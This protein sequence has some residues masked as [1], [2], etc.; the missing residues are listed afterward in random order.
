MSTLDPMGNPSPRC[1]RSNLGEVR[2]SE[3]LKSMLYEDLIWDNRGGSFALEVSY[4]TSP[5]ELT[6]W[7]WEHGEVVA[8]YNHI[9]RGLVKRRFRFPL[10]EYRRLLQ[11]CEKGA[12]LA[13]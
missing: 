13:A 2:I 7:M 11:A 1:H 12:R 4:E 6:D 5:K 9:R 10:P 3:N 8:E